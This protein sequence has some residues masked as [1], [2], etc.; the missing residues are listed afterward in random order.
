[1]LV[2]I[3]LKGRNEGG[4]SNI[5]LTNSW[6]YAKRGGGRDREGDR[7]AMKGG[8]DGRT[9]CSCEMY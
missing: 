9:V 5:L 1:M 2:W 8:R 6:F 3:A 7:K 4:S